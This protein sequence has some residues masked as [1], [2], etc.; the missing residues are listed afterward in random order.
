MEKVKKKN[1]RLPRSSILD[2]ANYCFRGYFY[3]HLTT[4]VRFIDLKVTMLQIV[5]LDTFDPY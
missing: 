3:C 5:L 2:K 4:H 1:K